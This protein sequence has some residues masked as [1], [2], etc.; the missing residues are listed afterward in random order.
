[1]V[2]VG[3]TE[4]HALDIARQNNSTTVYTSRTEKDFAGMDQQFER[5]M[6]K[7]NIELVFSSKDKIC[8]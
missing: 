5:V 6:D 7:E 1:V 2:R 4:D 3:F 8:T